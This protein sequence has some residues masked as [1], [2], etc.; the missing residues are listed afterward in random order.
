[1]TRRFAHRSPLTLPLLILPLVSLGLPLLGAPACGDGVAPSSV[2][3]D[4]ELLAQ[5]CDEADWVFPT[6]PGQYHAVMPRLLI[7]DASIDGVAI[8]QSPPAGE[9]LPPGPFQVLIDREGEAL[10]DVEGLVTIDERTGAHPNIIYHP[11]NMGNDLAE[12]FFEIDSLLDP[13]GDPYDF[14]F[15]LNGDEIDGFALGQYDAL[16]QPGP[17][18]VHILGVTVV[19]AWA[20]VTSLWFSDFFFTN[21]S[22]L[23]DQEVVQWIDARSPGSW[24]TVDSGIGITAPDPTRGACAC[25]MVHHPVNVADGFCGEWPLAVD[26]DAP[27][28][29]SRLRCMPF[30]GSGVWGTNLLAGVQGHSL[31]KSTNGSGHQTS[32]WSIVCKRGD[33]RDAEVA[34]CPTPYF[35]QDYHLSAGPITAFASR[36]NDSAHARVSAK[37]EMSGSNDAVTLHNSVA[38]GATTYTLKTGTEVSLGSTFGTSATHGKDGPGGG[39]Q[40]T[41]EF[42]VRVAEEKQWA[43]DGIGFSEAEKTSYYAT[44]RTSRQGVYKIETTATVTLVAEVTTGDSS[45]F[46]APSPTAWAGGPSPSG[47]L[48]GGGVLIREVLADFRCDGGSL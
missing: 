23:S 7:D 48:G 8:V 1:M 24:K 2:L 4:R 22:G 33:A 32:E 31:T 20:R 41:F 30:G 45:G 11:A 27:S 25:V 15:T 19:D 9:H 35:V 12:P 3:S 37:V 29:E 6:A 17:G 5:W 42:K 16:Y 39:V 34:C 40:E 47:L 44:L 28:K 26:P 46:L 13:A 21:S 38:S 18:N 36:G 10:C 14:T 43:G